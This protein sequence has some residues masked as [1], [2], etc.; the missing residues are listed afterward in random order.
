VTLALSPPDRERL[1]KLLGMLGSKHQGERDAAG[2][3]A[4]RLVRAAGL[5]WS[6]V[7][8]IPQ[9]E[10]VHEHHADPLNWRMTAAR[11]RQFETLINRWEDEFLAGLPRFPRLS[12]KQRNTLLAIVSRLRACGCSL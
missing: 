7:V 3:A 12:A 10:P 4:D 2:L 11:C 6:H 5:S 8:C 1:A 9:S